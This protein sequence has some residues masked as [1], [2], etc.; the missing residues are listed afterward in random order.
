MLAIVPVLE[1]SI[2]LE[3]ELHACL[4]TCALSSYCMPYRP[5]HIAC[6]QPSQQMARVLPAAEGLAYKLLRTAQC[7]FHLIITCTVCS[8]HPITFCACSPHNP[9]SRQL[10]FEV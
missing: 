2:E 8:N 4:S 5:E 10:W 7:L 3:L 9:P 6:L 1:V